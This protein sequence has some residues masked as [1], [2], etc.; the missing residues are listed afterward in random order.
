M[1]NLS[2]VSSYYRPLTSNRVCAY[3]YANEKDLP[4]GQR[5][6]Q[7]SK[8]NEVCYQNVDFQ[9]LHWPTHKQV[10]CSV[11]KDD[12]RIHQR[13][14]D[15][16][17]CLSMIENEYMK[18]NKRG[19]LLLHLLQEFK[20]LSE[21]TG[22]SRPTPSQAQSLS[23]CS[24]I[25]NM[26]GQ[27]SVVWAMPGF[28]NYFLSEQVLLTTEMEQAKE[29][30]LHVEWDE[31]DQTKV[32]FGHMVMCMLRNASLTTTNVHDLARGSVRSGPLPA[33]AMRRLMQSWTC[34]Y[35]RKSTP[36]TYKSV[37]RAMLHG[38]PVGRQ[39]TSVNQALWSTFF[40]AYGEAHRLQEWMHPKELV[41]GM[42]LYSL[43]K[44]MVTENWF[45]AALFSS[46]PESFVQEVVDFCQ[47]AVSLPDDTLSTQERLELLDLFHS[48]RLFLQNDLTAINSAT[49]KRL[50]V[51]MVSGKR[52][53]VLIDMYES[54]LLNK[55]S[56]DRRTIKMVKAK[57]RNIINNI[58][59]CVMACF[60]CILGSAGHENQQGASEGQS[61]QV[62]D[63]GKMTTS[64][65]DDIIPI[66]ATFALPDECGFLLD[67]VEVVW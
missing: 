54:I 25:M 51:H 40:G 43:L 19:R 13:F 20:R 32:Y 30:E 34:P 39:I 37:S 14:D 46:R 10:C 29:M 11:A 48:W 7:C 65:P 45:F 42:S 49:L 6:L 3:S 35:A 53:S 27:N 4:Q 1:S 31:A 24:V 38:Q 9:R 23:S 52:T 16:S 58:R 21:A 50:V 17:S 41:P 56:I 61:D 28:C 57:R 66:I 47:S 67:H 26:I 62:K 5:L 22:Q 36:I 63:G 2:A 44:L 18:P 8:C 64:F 60:E 12:P 33:A 15:M 59:P 55:A